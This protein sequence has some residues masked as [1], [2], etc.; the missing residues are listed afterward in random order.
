MT[1]NESIPVRVGSAAGTGEL[2]NLTSG[3]PDHNS[4]RLHINRLR[5]RFAM[6]EHMAALVVSLAGLGLREIR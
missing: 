3:T 4:T 2:A 6:S 1:T 5:Q